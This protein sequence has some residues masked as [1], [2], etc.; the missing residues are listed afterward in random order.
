MGTHQCEYVS[1]ED[2][3]RLGKLAGLDQK[4]IPNYYHSGGFGGDII[5]LFDSGNA[6]VLPKMAALYL[7]LGWVPPEGFMN[8]I[9]KSNLV[10]PVRVLPESMVPKDMDRTSI[11][12]AKEIGYLSPEAD[13][14][15]LQV[16][17]QL[18]PGFIAQ[19]LK[20]SEQAVKIG[21]PIGTAGR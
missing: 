5:M 15:P 13:P 4:E 9:M 11:T 18:P 6:W 10:K 16:S 7:A 17:S 2:A 1:F 12:L 21:P 8:D 20:Q 19:Y 14:L 3:I